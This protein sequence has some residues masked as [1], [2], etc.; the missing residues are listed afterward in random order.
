[1]NVQVL[2][3]DK[4][5]YY[6]REDSV[7]KVRPRAVMVDGFLYVPAAPIDPNDSDSVDRETAILAGF[8]IERV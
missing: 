7:G 4:S 2:L 8:G 3:W 6:L 5:V 1:M